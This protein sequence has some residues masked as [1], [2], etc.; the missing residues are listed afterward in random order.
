MAEAVGLTKN[1]LKWTERGIDGMDHGIMNMTNFKTTSAVNTSG[2]MIDNHKSSLYNTSSIVAN[3]TTWLSQTIYS[4]MTTLQQEIE[5]N[6]SSL[7]MISTT[8]ESYVMNVTVNETIMPSS[9]GKF[10][11][12]LVKNTSGNVINQTPSTLTE[13]LNSTNEDRNEI[14]VVMTST[15]LGLLILITVIGNVFVIAAILLE[16]N[17]QSVGNYLVLSLAAAD[18]LVAILVMPLGAVYEVNKMWIMGP[19]L[20]DMWTASDVLCCTASILHLLA[21]A[22]DRYWAVTN[23]NYIHNRTSRRICTMIFI[24]WFVAFAVSIPPVFGLKDPKFPHRLHVLKKC[25]LSQDVV[26]QIVATFSSFYVPLVLTLIL[27]W[28]IYQTARKRIRR[29]AKKKLIPP[30]RTT[31]GGTKINETTAFNTNNSSN[32][33]S[34]EKSSCGGTN[35]SNSQQSNM[36]EMSKVEMLP[37]KERKSTKESIEHKRERKAAKTLAIITGVFVACW[38]PFFVTALV[39]PVCENCYLPPLLQSFMLWLGYC[40]SLLNPIIYTIFSPDFRNAFHK[41]LCREPNSRNRRP[42]R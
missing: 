20:C 9:F 42:T 31:I 8:N 25:L 10:V 30:E 3:A 27:Y 5:G 26:Y 29:K 16:K 23:I 39:M 15:I 32:N 38:L 22:L 12:Y 28:K 18:L 1:T 14:Y 19:E 11:P 37:K 36:S 13:P 34:P 40:N 17:L 24:V 2:D 21:I 41:I 7:Q 4:N 33:A 35:Y 6:V